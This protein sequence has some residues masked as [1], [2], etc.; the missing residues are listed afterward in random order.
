MKKMTYTAYS[1]QA[2]YCTT[3]HIIWNALLSQKILK[4]GEGTEI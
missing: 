4:R 3:Y 2:V 1:N